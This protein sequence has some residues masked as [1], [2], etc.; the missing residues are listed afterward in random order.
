M[1]M[2]LCCVHPH[3]TSLNASWSEVLEFPIR[4]RDQLMRRL[5]EIRTKEVSAIRSRR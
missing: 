5:D 1:M 2:Y 3:V 4:R